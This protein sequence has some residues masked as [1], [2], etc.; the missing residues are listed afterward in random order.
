[1]EAGIS[2]AYLAIGRKY[3]RKSLRLYTTLQEEAVGVE[4][5][6]RHAHEFLQGLALA[7]DEVEL[8]IIFG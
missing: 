8:N 4:V 3:K 5:S 1:M 2:P 6:I 7:S